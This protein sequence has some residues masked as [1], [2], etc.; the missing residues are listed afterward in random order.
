[1]SQPFRDFLHAAPPKY[2]LPDE[3]TLRQRVVENYETLKPK[4]EKL[5]TESDS[6][7]SLISDGLS[8]N[9]LEPQIS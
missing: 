5:V 3:K 4:V 1:M 2:I 7:K 9:V 8:S 6:L